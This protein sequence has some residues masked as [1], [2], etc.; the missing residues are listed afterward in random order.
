MSSRT[1]RL[2]AVSFFILGPVACLH[3]AATSRS[4]P[5]ASGTAA[6]P[7]AESVRTPAPAETPS[8]AAPGPVAL[9]A[10]PAGDDSFRSRVQ[11]ILERR[12]TPCHF[13]G[14]RMYDRLPFD[15][16]AVVRSKSESLLRRLK[17]AEEHQTV[18]EWLHTP[19]AP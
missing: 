14:G 18:E 16:A 11:P 17:V 4:T 1:L 6:R 13:P 5:L 12:C 8:A 9:T 3:P 7:P 2:T 15:R 10:A 19:P